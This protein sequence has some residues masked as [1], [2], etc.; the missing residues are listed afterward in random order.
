MKK[1]NAWNVR[2]RWLV[3]AAASLL[4]ATVAVDMSMAM[5]EPKPTGASSD[6]SKT[7]EGPDILIFKDGK[8]FYG[9]IVSE[10][11]TS[12]R[13]KGKVAGLDF[14]TE[15]PKAD[16]L[17]MKKGERK[18]D[19]TP[20]AVAA[21]PVKAATPGGS[22]AAPAAP[23]ATGDGKNRYYWI[24]L[25]GELGSQISETPLR[26]AITDA[27]K[28]NANTIIIEYDPVW[29]IDPRNPLPELAANIDEM[30][31]AERICEVFTDDIPKD[32]SMRPRIAMWVKDAMG[33][34]AFLPI[35]VPELYFASE[36]R[37][38][39]LGNL[40]DLFDGVGD[41][42]VRLKQRS[43]RLGHAE[44]WCIAGGY[45]FRLI[46]AMS[47]RN[48]VL[49]YRMSG[50]KPELFEGYPTNAGEELLTDDGKDQN[51]DGVNQ[52]LRGDGGNDVLTINARLAEILGLSRRTV[53]TRDDLLAAMDIALDSVEVKG[54]SKNIMRDWDSGVE[55]TKRTLLKLMDDYREVR[56]QP[57]GDQ[58]AR[59]KARGQRRSIL[60]QMLRLIKGKFGEGLSPR[61]LGE[62][63][64][65]SESDINTIL[66]QIKI[67][68]TKDRK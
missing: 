39:G 64:I 21:D 65:P 50:G 2:W 26:E 8:V 16:I 37:M 12:V 60:E 62:N 14:E 51:A 53:D 7:G 17:Q 31:R 63:G 43:L 49:S 11:A 22:P 9:T 23:V 54:R 15:Y 36:A 58:A 40:G 18:A 13:F 10:T 4:L 6:A 48:F 19:G 61:W 34:S 32:W 47:F 59:T 28:N 25:K 67:E 1:P 57:P 29:N 20:A 68:Q 27:R 42:V 66:E 52:V 44:G 5:A 30:W 56:V 38:G 35:V 55:S 3:G 41:E 45:D 33:G 24:E 46:R